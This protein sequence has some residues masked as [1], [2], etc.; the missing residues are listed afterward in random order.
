[1]KKAHVLGRVAG[2]VCFL[3]VVG[4]EGLAEGGF[5]D[6]LLD[7][8][9]DQLEFGFGGFFHEGGTLLWGVGCC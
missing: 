9:H 8:G 7:E 1:M 6:F 2:E 3:S 4:F 5:V